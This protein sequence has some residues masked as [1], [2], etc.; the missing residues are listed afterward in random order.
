[1]CLAYSTRSAGPTIPA[2]KRVD[3]TEID[4][5]NP[6]PVWRNS[7]RRPFWVGVIRTFVL[8]NFPPYVF[9]RSDTAD[10]ISQSMLLSLCVETTQITVHIVLSQRLISVGVHGECD[11]VVPSRNLC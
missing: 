7:L 6:S 8:L 2:Q 9:T 3:R 4:D 10:Q 5:I 11:N 1:M